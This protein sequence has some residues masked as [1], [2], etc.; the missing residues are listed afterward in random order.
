MKNKS[1]NK[2]FPCDCEKFNYKNVI[3]VAR[4]TFICKKC[5]KDIS[6]FWILYCDAQSL[7][8]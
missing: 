8:K 3:R 5:K 2:S 4:A 7:S 6:M 1:K